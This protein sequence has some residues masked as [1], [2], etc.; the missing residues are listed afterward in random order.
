M[1]GLAGSISNMLV[2]CVANRNECLMPDLEQSV[3]KGYIVGPF[4]QRRLE[5]QQRLVDSGSIST[6]RL[7]LD[8]SVLWSIRSVTRPT[9]ASHKASYPP[10]PS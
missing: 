6:V 2:R 9:K 8:R 3:E 5:Q 1:V 7:V 10:P 4:L